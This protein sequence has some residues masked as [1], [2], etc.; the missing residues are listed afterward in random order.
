MAQEYVLKILYRFTD[1]D[2]V[3]AR[4]RAQT[5]LAKQPPE[6]FEYTLRSLGTRH[7]GKSGKVVSSGF[8]N[9]DDD[10]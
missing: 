7:Q 8:L 5:I 1:I 2:D 9:D 4:T 10:G 6:A 3:E